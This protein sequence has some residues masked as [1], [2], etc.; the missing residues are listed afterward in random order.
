MLP[1]DIND[2]AIIEAHK[3]HVEQVFARLNAKVFGG[4]GGNKMSDPTKEITDLFKHNKGQLVK[5]LIGAKPDQLMDH[6]AAFWRWLDKDFTHE[7]YA[8]YLQ[9]KKALAASEKDA[10]ASDGEQKKKKKEPVVLSEPDKN[11]VKAYND[12]NKIIAQLFDYERWFQNGN[13]SPRYDSY[14]LAV[15]LGRPTCTYCN[16]I[17]TGTMKTAAGKKVMRPTF[18]HWFPQFKYPLLA[19]SFYNLIPSCSVCNSSVKGFAELKLKEHE[20]PYMGKDLIGKY[21]FSYDYQG[22]INRYKIKMLTQ[23]GEELLKAT[24][25]VQK[26]DLIYD[27]HQ[28]EL[29]DLIL[30]AES[31]SPYYIN[32]IVELFPN[33]GL[34]YNEAYRLAFSTEAYSKDFYKRPLSKFKYDILKELLRVSHDAENSPKIK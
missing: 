31:N 24:L 19:L 29:S 20:H 15:N 2:P 8:D 10:Q 6:V 33:S 4:K 25:A 14:T 1:I 18:D 30:L 23:P 16:R 22:G 27:V 17:Y 13:N 28:T 26:L 3:V 9:L 7:K 32:S 12:W 21:R 34:S 11:L 5:D